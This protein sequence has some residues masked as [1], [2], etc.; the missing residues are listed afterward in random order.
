MR[1][2]RFAALAVVLCLAAVSL[3][4]GPASARKKKRWSTER[5][6]AT[7][8]Q[9]KYSGVDVSTH[10]LEAEDGTQLSLTLHLPQGLPSG[11][12]IPT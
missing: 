10:Y 5:W 2:R 7:L 8:S 6:K 11:A 9:P 3:A 12:R 1:T 4:A